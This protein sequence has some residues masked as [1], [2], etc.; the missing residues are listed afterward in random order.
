MAKKKAKKIRSGKV[1]NKKPKKIV[2]PK[3]SKPIV[4]F[5][6]PG[7]WKA[8]WWK[9]LIIFAIPFLLYFQSTQFGYVLDDQIV[10]TENNFTKKGFAGIGDLMTTE[11]MTGYFGEQRNLVQGNRYRPFSLITFAIEYDIFGGLKPGISHFINILFYALT[12]L[13]LFRVLS[14]M[15]RKNKANYWWLS[16]P[17]LT[18]LFFIAHPIHSE[19]VANIKGRDEILA[20]LFSFA[21]LYT[22]LR[23][24]DNKKITWLLSSCAIFF[25][26]LLSK[27]NSITFLAVIPLTVYFFSEHKWKDNFK[28]LGALVVTTIIYLALRFSVAGVPE[29][30]KEITDLMNNPFLG[31]SGNEKLATIMFTLYKYI[32]LYIFP[33]P[34]NHDYYPYAHFCHFCTTQRQYQLSLNYHFGILDGL[35]RPYSQIHTLD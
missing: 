21:T 17:L 15:F 10:I 4:P 11:S 1:E 12:G 13:L 33:H 8:N 14:M 6:A 30:G 27:E 3:V 28:L 25:I 7:F 20:L 9:A 2:K 5:Y 22:G 31:M 35:K 34:L 24:L 32:Q 18:S 26:A 16:I 29:F 23:Y 19:A